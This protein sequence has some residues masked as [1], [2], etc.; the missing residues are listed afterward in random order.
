MML[1][2]AVLR[3]ALGLTLLWSLGVCGIFVLGQ[4]FPAGQLLYFNA[5]QNNTDPDIYILDMNQ[6]IAHAL[7]HNT[8][9]NRNPLW[10]PDGETIVFYSDRPYE[11]TF[12]GA[13][14]LMAANGR[15]F[16]P[17]IHNQAEIG[18]PLSRPVW[19]PDGKK[20]ALILQ[21]IDLRP[22]I[23]IVDVT[24]QMTERVTDM[25]IIAV[26]LTWTPDSQRVRFVNNEGSVY[27]LYETGIGITPQV[28]HE[29]RLPER[30]GLVNYPVLSPDANYAILTLRQSFALDSDLYLMDLRDNETHNLTNTPDDAETTPLFSPGGRQLV[31]ASW[32]AGIGS[33]VVMDTDGQNRRDVLTGAKHELHPRSWS[34]DSQYVIFSQ[35]MQ[36]CLISIQGGEIVCPRDVPPDAVWRPQPVS[37]AG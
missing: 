2:G 6:N 5:V 10:S 32:R 22:Q 3:L 18:S 17:L 34:P 19:S 37:A 31:F 33:L 13:L 15:Q 25:K 27:R 24:T 30:Y 16:R 20:M 8:S 7:T 11:S 26:P 28:L 9:Q 29:W 36:M 4:Q 14:Y 21:G 35:E 1:R 12:R 23:Y